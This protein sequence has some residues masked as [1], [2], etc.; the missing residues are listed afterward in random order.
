MF[1]DL[2]RGAARQVQSTSQT[3]SAPVGVLGKRAVAATSYLALVVIVVGIALRFWHLGAD[4]AYGAWVG[5]IPDEGRWVEGARG[6]VLHA[7]T[8]AGLAMMHTIVA[9][10]FEAATFVAFEIFGVSSW[11]SRLFT[12]AS[13]SA[14]LIVLWVMLKRAVGPHAA[15]FGLALLAF[16]PDLFAISRMAIPEVPSIVVVLGAYWLITD[17]LSE[18]RPRTRLLLAGLVTLCATGL[19]FN[20]AFFLVIGI[21]MIVFAD[22]RPTSIRTRLANSVIYCVPAFSAAVLAIVGALL[23]LGT[24]AVLVNLSPV[25]DALSVLVQ[26]AALFQ[27]VSGLFEGGF[28]WTVNVWAMGVWFSALCGVVGIT[29]HVDLA[30]RTHLRA[31]AVWIALYAP[32]TMALAYFPV[33][34][35]I[36]VLLP[37]LINVCCGLSVLHRVGLSAIIAG[38]VATRGWRGIVS[39]C[40]LVV[41]SAVFFGSVLLQR[42]G[43]VGLDT[44][45]LSTSLIVLAAAIA[46]LAIVVVWKRDSARLTSFFLLFPALTLPV[47]VLVS[48]TTSVP[49][50]PSGSGDTGLTLRVMALL[51]IAV[52][53]TTTRPA[54]W[55]SRQWHSLTAA[56]ALVI[57][58]WTAVRA[59]SDYVTPRYTIEE[60]SRDLG[61]VLAA[62]DSIAAIRS[63]GMFINNRLVYGHAYNRASC[64]VVRQLL[65]GEHRE[66]ITLRNEMSGRI[67]VLDQL[68]ATYRL[69]KTYPLWIAPSFCEPRGVELADCKMRV[70]AYVRSGTALHSF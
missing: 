38:T 59:A 8:P 42:A 30:G 18:T 54:T 65:P 5:Y 50:W 45:R 60:A 32:L 24:Q 12:A 36:H 49:F 16:Q 33:Y 53:A 26:P 10:V 67:T 31:S 27:M 14:L 40:L 23:L 70:N 20:N 63:E 58:G 55:A 9:P 68:E 17:Y 43:A 22:A 21:A 39:R 37:I 64:I 34:Y 48:T 56:V 11:S 41:P 62:C 19:K 4:P 7:S 69:V 51:L 44:V 35:K 66:P 46:L 25:S 52:V 57:F 2:R 13:G 61:T 6:L 47:V 15:L 28:T 3:L 29:R 1:P